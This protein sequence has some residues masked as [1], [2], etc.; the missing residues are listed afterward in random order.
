[1]KTKL[2]LS[3]ALLLITIL[4]YAQNVGINGTGAVPDASAMLDVVSTNRGMLV[5]RVALTATNAAGPIT[6][7][8]TSLLVYNTATAGASPNN[9]LPGYYYWDGAKWVSLSGGTGGNDWSLLGNAGTSAGTNF[10]GTTDATDIVFKRNATQAGIINTLN[11][12][13]GVD[14]LLATTGV[15]NTAIGAGSLKTN[16]GG[17]SNTAGGYLSLTNA[18]ASR[19]TAFGAQTL[20]NTTT[21]DNTAVG[22]RAGFT[23]TLGTSNTYVGSGADATVNNF[24]NA[25]AIGFNA[26]VGASNAIVLGG[27]GVN[28]ANVG[29]G[30]TSPNASAKLDVTAT[31]QGFLPPRMTTA[32]MIAIPSPAAGL[33]VYNV[34]CNILEYWNGTIWSRMS[35]ST[36]NASI[37]SSQTF[38]YTGAVQNVTVPSCMTSATIKVWG[39]G[40]GGGG[41]DGGNTGG[42]GGG[43]AYSTV[44]VAVTPGDVLQ[45]YVGG[46]GTFGATNVAGTGSGVGG[47]GYANG[48][49]GGTAG[50]SGFS[51]SGGG[52]AGSSAVI[53][54]TTSTTLA[55]AGGGGGAGGGGNAGAPNG[56]GGNAG[57]GGQAGAIGGT[58]TIG[59]AASGNGTGVGQIGVNRGAGDG[60]GGGGGNTNGGAAGSVNII[61]SDYGAAGGGGGG[62]LG[63]VTIGALQTP[64]N[65][66]DVD[67]CAGCA[68][69]GN[70]VTTGTNGMV[71]IYW[72]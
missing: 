45:V 64:G 55:V 35:S 71:K 4:T 30:T 22:Y 66:A 15:N 58:G 57:A 32:Q 65:A 14:A 28:A 51:G 63:T 59:G 36:Y 40:G 2:L 60:G 23:N 24:T 21:A 46:A 25:T 70:A 68:T 10:I 29:I 52:G 49:N 12:G 26:K 47:F 43:G 6:A 54:S 19:N 17:G 39:A 41:N 33:M 67:L 1:M 42:K 56:A 3:T 7:P 50:T 16:I 48:G 31:N 9:V 72:N 38:N 13:L 27:T 5:P 62:S 44:T 37:V 34:D 69:G 61:A 11:T 20:Q 18:N 53:N 8:L